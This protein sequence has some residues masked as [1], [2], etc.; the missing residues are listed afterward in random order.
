[1]DLA[2]AVRTNQLA[3]LEFLDDSSPGSSIAFGSDPELLVLVNVVE[4]QCIQ[5]TIVTT[6]TTTSAQELNRSAF[7]ALPFLCDVVLEFAARTTESSL[8]SDQSVPTTMPGTTFRN[9]RLLYH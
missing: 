9:S 6:Q 5:A 2:V 7:Q 1:M 3:F 4:G 8:P